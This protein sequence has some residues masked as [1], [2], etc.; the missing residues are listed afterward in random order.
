ML[1]LYKERGISWLYWNGNRIG[2]LFVHKSLLQGRRSRFSRFGA[3][4]HSVG[5]C[6]CARPLELIILELL[7]IWRKILL[8]WWMILLLLCRQ[9]GTLVGK[10]VINF[11]VSWKGPLLLCLVL[12]CW[13]R[14]CWHHRRSAVHHF[15]RCRHFLDPIPPKMVVIVVIS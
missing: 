9:I 15:L 14:R 6:S 1:L 3:V 8:L 13:S 10:W 5:V 7:L 12:H 4:P 2:I 11:F